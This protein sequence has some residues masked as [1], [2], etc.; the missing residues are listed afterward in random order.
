MLKLIKKNKEISFICVLYGIISL[1]LFFLM[2]GGNAVI[3]PDGL[4]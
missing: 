3:G 1:V 2:F 4:L